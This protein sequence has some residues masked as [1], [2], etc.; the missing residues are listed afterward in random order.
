ML[1]HWTARTTQDYK[2]CIVYNTVAQ[3]DHF[4]ML[5]NGDYSE[6]FLV[7]DPGA[8]SLEEVI[9][10][11]RSHGLKL[12]MLAYDDGDPENKRGPVNSEIFVEC[13]KRCGKPIDFFELEEKN[14]RE[15][16][17]ANSVENG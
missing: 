13:W 11:V 17:Q 15:R 12:V 9:K 16:T 10:L 1:Q 14:G 3:L 8:V 7:D 4:L 5:K 6:H 2:Y